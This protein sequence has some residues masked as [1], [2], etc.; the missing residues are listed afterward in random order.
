MFHIFNIDMPDAFNRLFNSA[1][2]EDVIK[3]RRG[4]ILTKAC[5]IGLDIKVPIVRTTT[6]YDK[7][8]QQFRTIHDLLVM[9]IC[10]ATS[11]GHQLNF[12]NALIEV[13]DDTYKT[14]KYHSDQAQDLDPDSDIAIY[15]CYEHPDMAPNRKLVI[16]SKDDMCPIQEITLRTNSVVLF[17]AK[18][19]QQYRHKIV[20]DNTVK[21]PG[22]RWLGITMRKSRT[23]LTFSPCSNSTP[24]LPDGRKLHL[25][26]SD[27]AREYYQMRARE[28]RGTDGVYPDLDYTI[29]PGDLIVVNVSPINPT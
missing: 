15:T 3:G 16:Q 13:Y 18:T 19:N 14:M 2:F 17:S 4:A 24:S 6:K 27:D 28:N 8:A 29:S 9:A 10:N 7:P 11:C 22:N 12:N 26:T 21:S 5:Q 1:L 25:A 23:I 20:L